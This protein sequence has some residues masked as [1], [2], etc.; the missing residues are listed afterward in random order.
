MAKM[1][2]CR[3]ILVGRNVVCEGD[4]FETD[5]QHA[6]ELVAKGYAEMLSGD[7]LD[8]VTDTDAPAE[9]AAAPRKGRK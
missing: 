5:E 8:A 6:R 1:K 2:A 9:A 3:P 4:E 7:V